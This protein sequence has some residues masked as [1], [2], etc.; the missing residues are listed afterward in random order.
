MY[1]VSGSVICTVS[2]AVAENP[3]F[4]ACSRSQLRTSR[5]AATTRHNDKA[6]SAVTRAPRSRFPQRPPGRA[7]PACSF[8]LIAL[9]L[10]TG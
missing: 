5:E 3:R 9:Q 2:T 7:L 4:S 6:I 8:A 1:F 10:E